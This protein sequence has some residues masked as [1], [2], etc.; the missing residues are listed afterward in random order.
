MEKKESRITGVS[1]ENFNQ[2]V[3]CVFQ[4]E[5]YSV[6]DNG[7]VL[8]HPRDGKRMRHYDN[9]WTFGNLNS[10]TGYLEIASVRI[11][12]IVSTAFH[13]EPLTKEHVVDHIDTNRQ[14]NRPENLRWVTRLENA[15][16]NPITRK[17]IILACG[18][19]EAFLE[20]PSILRE[21]DIDP[22][23]RWMRTVNPKEAQISR[24]RLLAWAKSDKL[25]SGGYL[26][27]WIYNHPAQ[28]DQPIEI[29]VKVP[30]FVTAKT[31]NAIQ[32]NWRIP[33]EF[34][35]CPQ[36]DYNQPI[37][38]YAENLKEGAIF[39]CN[40]IYTSFVR[41]STMSGDH[42]SLYV[43]SES[44]EKEKAVKPWGLAKIAYEDGLF[45][46]TNLGSFFTIEGVEKQ[47]CLAQ[48]FEW[49]GGESIDDY[50]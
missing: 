37:E 16:N 1:V 2:Q 49:T 20:N 28:Q 5:N 13:G 8:R 46:H 4:K 15:L 27:E 39:C 44:G 42:Q 47:Y 30:E 43:M 23:F 12:R 41:K 10:K 7:A 45:A 25:S 9:Q 22:D 26:G 11:H 33:S 48:G 21:N 40:D 29:E 24:D 31:S 34:P 17:R 6:R 18:S 35:C 3:E 32:Y 14:N 38:A 50:C 36:G 19:I